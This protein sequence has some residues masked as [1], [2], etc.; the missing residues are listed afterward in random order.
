M[1]FTNFGSL[2]ALAPGGTY[3]WWYSWGTNMGTQFASADVNTAN[4]S[5]HV[6]YDQTKRIDPDGTVKYTVTIKNIGNQWTWHNLQG[7]GVS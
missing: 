2:V 6:A 5:P 4:G 1:S 7:G 3:T